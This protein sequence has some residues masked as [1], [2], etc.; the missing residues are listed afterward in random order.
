VAGLVPAIDVETI[1]PAFR[2]RRFFQWMDANERRS[3][4]EYRR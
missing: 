1:Q 4:I 2:R 3:W